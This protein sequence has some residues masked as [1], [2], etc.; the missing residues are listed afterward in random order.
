MCKT[1]FKPVAS[2]QELHQV[3]VFRIM[4][5]RQA[6]ASCERVL[7]V[8]QVFGAELKPVFPFLLFFFL[9]HRFLFPTD[10]FF[11]PQKVSFTAAEICI[12][13][14]NFHACQSYECQ[15]TLGAP[16]IPQVNTVPV[17]GQMERGALNSTWN[18]LQTAGQRFC[19]ASKPNNNN[20]ELIQCFQNLK[21][22][23]NLKKNIRCTNTH[24]Y[25][26]Q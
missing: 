23:Y 6:I 8:S 3:N 10:S 15:I 18:P 2:P 11:S 7:Y 22:L 9:Y 24:D 5:P 1:A 12:F 25:T 21:T 16:C 19:Q 17:S 4:R 13:V 26:N 14:G 20:R